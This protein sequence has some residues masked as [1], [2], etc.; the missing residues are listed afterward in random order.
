MT[1]IINCV[2]CLED[3]GYN[4]YGDAIPAICIKCHEKEKE[5]DK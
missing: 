2:F 5:S 1:K 3:I 4:I